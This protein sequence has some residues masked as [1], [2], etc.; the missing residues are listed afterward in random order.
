MP[1]VDLWQAIAL[2]MNLEPGTKNVD[3]V[4]SDA[5]ENEYNQ[6]LL[7][8]GAH[9][10]TGQL[11]VLAWPPRRQ[12]ESME[13]AVVDLRTFGTFAKCIGIPIPPEY[14]FDP[15]NWDRWGRADV[16]EVW[17]AVAV[18]TQHSPDGVKFREAKSSF[19]RDFNEMLEVAMSCLRQSLPVCAYDKGT[20][21][22]GYR[23]DPP[24]EET[25]TKVRLDQFATWAL[26]KRYA[27]PDRF[28]RG[29][30]STPGDGA[31]ETL[32]NCEPVP[33]TAK[34]NSQSPDDASPTPQQKR[35]LNNLLVIIAA[36][37]KEAGYPIE[38]NPAAAASAIEKGIGEKLPGVRGVGED[39][40]TGYLREIPAI[41]A[42][43]KK[44][45]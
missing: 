45:D 15:V 23:D 16:A 11:V 42:S 27:L 38:E 40:I 2:S 18:A 34:D 17:Q 14:P 39:A 21:F 32:V 10:K 31:P 33:E 26:G 5:Q 22:D 9:I 25:K 7:L 36:L 19:G 6:R 8:A 20:M 37:G 12:S 24:T 1:Q 44:A 35:K 28:P 30:G 4:P 41:L 43:R 29:I 13:L 3:F